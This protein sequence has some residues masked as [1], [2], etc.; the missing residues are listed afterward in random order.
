MLLIVKIIFYCFFLVIDNCANILCQNGGT[1]ANSL[2]SYTCHCVV[3]YTGNVCQ[4]GE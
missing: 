1:C 3:G 2:N 4:T